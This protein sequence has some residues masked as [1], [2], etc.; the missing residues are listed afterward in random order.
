MIPRD[1]SKDAEA[2]TSLQAEW[3]GLQHWWGMYPEN[4][5]FNKATDRI[6][7]I[8]KEIKSLDLTGRCGSCR[9][10]HDERCYARPSTFGV[11]VW[12]WCHEWSQKE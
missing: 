2:I 3:D 12:N 7:E 8:E 4:E 6:V 1:M 9:H 11:R 5:E 10:F